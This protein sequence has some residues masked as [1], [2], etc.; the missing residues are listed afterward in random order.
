MQVPPEFTTIQPDSRFFPAI[1]YVE[2]F[3][4][5]NGTLIT[6][7]DPDLK[8][9]PQIKLEPQ[10]FT[11]E[12]G[13]LNEGFNVLHLNEKNQEIIYNALNNLT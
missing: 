9:V 6:V 11:C 13:T 5:L 2:I 12:G 3:Q 8:F 7:C 1:F 10:N 4:Y